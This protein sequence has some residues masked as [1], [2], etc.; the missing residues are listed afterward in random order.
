MPSDLP[1]L[2]RRGCLAPCRVGDR[3]QFGEAKDKI[4][5]FLRENLL[6]E[7]LIDL[8][9]VRTRRVIA[10][11]AGAPSRRSRREVSS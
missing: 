7:G 10:G 3:H 11:S 6:E 8:L 2:I 4:A 1:Y 5:T 9:R